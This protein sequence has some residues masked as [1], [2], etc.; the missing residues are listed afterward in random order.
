MFSLQQHNET[1]WKQME[2]MILDHTRVFG[3]RDLLRWQMAVVTPWPDGALTAQARPF[4]C[5]AG[6]LPHLA[7]TAS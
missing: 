3:G 1:S 4:Y 7:R 6:M 2:K 5:L